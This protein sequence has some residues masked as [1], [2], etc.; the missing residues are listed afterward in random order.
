MVRRKAHRSRVHRKIIQA[1]RLGTV[2][3]HS[4]H[5]MPGW[6]RADQFPG[7]IVDPKVDELAQTPVRPDHTER[8]EPRIGQLHCCL[9]DVAQGDVQIKTGGHRED[10]L[11]QR[12]HPV[13]GGTYDVF[14]PVMHLDQQFA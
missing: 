14:H 13:P 8:A 12:V 6:Q 5:T 11:Q 3:D 9:N 2:D 4:E 1:K 7:A 10:S